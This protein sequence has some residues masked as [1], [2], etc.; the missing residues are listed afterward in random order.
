MT[1]TDNSPAWSGVYTTGLGLTGAIIVAL[2][3]NSLIMVADTLGSALDFGSILFACLTLRAVR[4]GSH[5]AFDYGL[6]KLENLVSLLIGFFILLSVL[7]LF[8]MSV[9]R[10]YHP[11]RLAG[12]GVFLAIA[13][14]ITFLVANGVLYLRTSQQ[15]R[16]APSP[17]VEAQARV[18]FIKALT[19]ASVAAVFIVSLLV[20]A[21]WARHLDTIAAIGLALVMIRSAWV[22][23]RHS[24]RDLLDHSAAE[25]LQLTINR[26][27]VE[28]FHAYASLKKV[29]T[30][31]SG[32]DWFVE[33]FLG[34]EAS[35]TVG[36][37]AMV[38]QSI[39]SAVQ[40]D[41]PAA[42]VEVIPPVH[43]T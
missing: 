3:S 17:V 25:P 14:A 41:F 9:Y 29:R 19:D 12:I 15:R 32:R 16:T 2:T 8:A 36:D 21:D 30:R 11:V 27:L 37:V 33:V 1:S 43:V 40:K 34:F 39:R 35:A 10:L 38:T 4:R 28:H 23:I 7:L 18:Y 31:S 13:L 42:Q 6:G 26:Q 22:L 20:H 5:A 24:V